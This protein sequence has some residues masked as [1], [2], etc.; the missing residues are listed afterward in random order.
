MTRLPTISSVKL[1]RVL[2][3]LGFQE[4]PAKGSHVFLN[5]PDGRTTTVPVHKGEDIG[6]GLL[7]KILWDIQLEPEDF[8]KLL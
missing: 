8:Q 4:F 2:R 7:R 3:K 6:R 5:H 1:L